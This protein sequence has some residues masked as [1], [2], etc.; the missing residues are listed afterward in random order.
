MARRRG[1]DS[2]PFH[3]EQCPMRGPALSHVRD[4]S[5]Q[6]VYCDSWTRDRPTRPKIADPETG[7]SLEFTELQVKRIEFLRHLR[8]TG[9]L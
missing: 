5:A 2:W 7:T 3:D 1:D 9:R 4:G 8:V 6:C